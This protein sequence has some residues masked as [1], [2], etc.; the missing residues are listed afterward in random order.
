MYALATEADVD[1]R[2][3]INDRPTNSIYHAGLGPDQRQRPQE[4][5][6]LNSFIRVTSTAIADA[7]GKLLDA[8]LPGQ[9]F[10]KRPRPA[11]RRASH[12]AAAASEG[13]GRT[14]CSD[15]S[16]SSLPAAASAAPTARLPDRIQADSLRYP[17]LRRDNRRPA[18]TAVPGRDRPPGAAAARPTPTRRPHRPPNCAAVRSQTFTALVDASK[19]TGG[20]G[21]LYPVPTSM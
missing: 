10:G 6:L 3:S 20:Y 11:Q 2:I 14:A 7:D 16:T 4:R 8:H 19:A 13:D 21:G 9:G 1:Q 5:L 17:N 15:W 18:A 12:P